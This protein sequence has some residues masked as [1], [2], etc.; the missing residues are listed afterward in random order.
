VA[1]GKTVDRRL[2][3]IDIWR[4][5]NIMFVIASHL[6]FGLYAG[7]VTSIDAIFG[8][9]FL[10]AFGI[11]AS[12][13]QMFFFLSGISQVLSMEKQLQ[14]GTPV[15]TIVKREVKKG[16]FLIAVGML[17]DPVVYWH[18][19]TVDTLHAIGLSY[20][21]LALLY[22]ATMARKTSID[23]DDVARFK[24]AGTRFFW[25][26][27]AV[28][29]ASPAVRMLTGWYPT[30]V[31]GA[32][33]L[34]YADPPM[35][36]FEGVQAWTTTSFF[37]VLPWIAYFF[38][39][40]W[41]ATRIIVAG[42]HG[43]AAKRKLA[44]QLAWMGLIIMVSGIVM[45]FAGEEI[46]GPDIM[47]PQSQQPDWVI[48]LSFNVQPLTTCT[49][50]FYLG[51]SMLVLGM[52]SFAF[53]VEHSYAHQTWIYNTYMSKWA[54]GIR[55]TFNTWVRFSYYS[56]T[57]YILQYAWIPVLRVIQLASGEQIM[58]TMP[59]TT[60]VTLIVAGSWILFAFV[61]RW[62]NTAGGNRFTFERL[63]KKVAG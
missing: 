16:I 33:P 2:P 3:S 59:D 23:G 39:G 55:A 41:I 30:F 19:G 10:L 37:P 38:A 27:V 50:V 42:K 61:A 49:F 35:N 28:A 63:L 31:T 47:L 18:F 46:A 15:D 24:R 54:R 17:Y 26:M 22:K 14:K 51:M 29:A 48:E 57:I 6:F 8:D 34:V 58:Y 56:L 13:G 7:S 25:G 12:V 52:L 40:A 32:E 43:E 11:F 20:I 36:F 45:L 4:G 53:E 60:I 44:K 62:L 9:P 5:I 1:R 21:I